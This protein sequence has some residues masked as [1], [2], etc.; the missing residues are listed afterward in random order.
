[1]TA[2]TDIGPTHAVT[3][4]ARGPR[5]AKRTA[6][7]ISALGLG[8]SAIALAVALY[9]LLSTG[10][11]HSIVTNSS[12]RKWDY[13]SAPDNLE[14]FIATVEQSVVEVKCQG[15]GSG[16]AFD[17]E[18]EQRGFTTVLVTNYHVIAEC[19]DEPNTIAI[20]STGSPY[21]S[22]KV[23]I[24]G[25]DKIG[26][27]ALLETDIQLPRLSAS[28]HFAERGWWSMAIGNPVDND[29]EPS[30]TLR[31]ATTFGNIAYVLNEFW[32]YTSA[33]INGGNSGGPLID[34]RGDVIGVNTLAAASTEE[35]VWNIA[36]DTAQLCVMLVECE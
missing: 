24:R 32:N 30:A 11:E 12:S 36:V 31:N 16:F 25:F 1:M 14:S 21:K 26:D 10:T 13:Y 17:V 18:P 23:R 22:A 6:V 8:V 4:A 27:L 5:Q 35:G 33:T 19:I 28:E 7:L 20:H 3:P 34:S 9:A 15:T 2:D 29:I